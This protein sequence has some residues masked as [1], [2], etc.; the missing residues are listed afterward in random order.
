M[1]RGRL[2]TGA[3]TALA[4]AGVLATGVQAVAAGPR[5]KAAPEAA[6]A[7]PTLDPKAVDILKAASARLAAAKSMT[8]TAVT[9]YE[10]PSRYQLPLA[11][12]TESEVSLQRPDKLRVLTPGD[13][14]ASEFYY[15]GKVM[16]AYAPADNL[17]AIADAPPTIDAT[18]AAVEADAATYFPFAP[19]LVTDPYQHMADR[20]EVAFIIGKSHI[21]GGVTTDVIAIANRNVFAQLWIGAEDKLPRRIRAIYADDPARLRHDLELSNW[22]IDGKI[23]AEV[24]TSTRAASA[25]RIKFARPDPQPPEEAKAAVER[26]RKTKQP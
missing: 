22:R 19:L 12:V 7:P 21:V 5:A 4:L 3:A 1:V 25:K 11:Y 16:M 8:F 15:D 14:P 17:V 24:F 9:T 23:P 13:G 2:M 26:G 6:V 10:N 18:L 20:L